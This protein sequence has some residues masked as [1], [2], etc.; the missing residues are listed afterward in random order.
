MDNM[1]YNVFV[2]GYVLLQD[3]LLDSDGEPMASDEAHAL[4]V[5]VYHQYI[6]SGYNEDL[7]CSGYDMLQKFVSERKFTCSVTKR[8][9]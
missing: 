4:C 2:L 6:E 5:D 8:T 9:I 3:R 1:D 7:S